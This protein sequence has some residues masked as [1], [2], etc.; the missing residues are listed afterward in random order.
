MECL[1][2][3]LFPNSI[4]SVDRDLDIPCVDE[5]ISPDSE[6]NGIKLSRAQHPIGGLL[7]Y[8]SLVAGK[9]TVYPKVYLPVKF[10]NPSGCHS[11]LIYNSYYCKNDLLITQAVERFY[12]HKN[13]GILGPRNGD[14][15]LGWVAREV[16]EAL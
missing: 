3:N 13:I 1:W 11:W 7:Y 6:E 8:Y 12:N 10:V 16:E 4:S 9:D 15:G 14:N 2:N 5:A